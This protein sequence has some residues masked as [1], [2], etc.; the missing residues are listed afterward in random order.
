MRRASASGD[1]AMKNSCHVSLDVGASEDVGVS[2][3]KASMD[4]LASLTSTEIGKIR[5][6]TV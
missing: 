6:L 1:Q 5:R 2:E 3:A 4:T